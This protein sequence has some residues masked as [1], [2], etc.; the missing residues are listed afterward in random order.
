[1]SKIDSISVSNVFWTQFKENRI[2]FSFTGLPESIHFTIAWGNT[3]GKMNL[4]ITKN[5]SNRSDKPRF[6]IALFDRHLLSQL[7]SF[8]PSAIFF[9]HFKPINFKSYS[10]KARRSTQI[11]FFDDLEKDKTHIQIKERLELAWN[12]VSTEKRNRL[13]I[14][15][16]F[17]KDFIP[18]INDYHF[19]T[20]LI[21]NLR[22]ITNRTF[23][24]KIFNA[25][26]ILIG[27]K[28]YPFFALNGKCYVAKKKITIYE[29]LCSFAKPEFVRSFLDYISEALDRLPMLRTYADSLPYNRPYQLY[30]EYES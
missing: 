13:K 18:L 8:V 1:M 6:Q 20:F 12:Q 26:V 2:S 14:K 19:R 11:L 27:T 30:I 21:R 28:T 22:P 17:E 3:T 5:T 29:L 7:S 16:E 10:R 23:K 9:S 24:N 25:G 15:K 4:H